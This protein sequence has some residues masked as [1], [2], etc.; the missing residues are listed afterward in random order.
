MGI[1]TIINLKKKTSYDTQYN[2]SQT[3]W[4]V[5]EYND[6]GEKKWGDINVG[7]IIK[8]SKNEVYFFDIYN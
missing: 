5:P 8:I 1:L 6:F 7:N 4:I 3:T 2:N